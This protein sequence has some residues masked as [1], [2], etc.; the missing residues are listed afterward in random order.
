MIKMPLQFL[1]TIQY[2]SPDTTAGKL[3]YEPAF[4]IVEDRLFV[5]RDFKNASFGC[6]SRRLNT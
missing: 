6:Q 4:G 5:I 1:I 3:W 2:Y